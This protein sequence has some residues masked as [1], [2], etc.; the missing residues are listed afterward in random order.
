M[1]CFRIPP[2]LSEHADVFQFG[3]FYLMPREIIGYGFGFYWL[4]SYPKD[5]LLTAAPQRHK[6][7]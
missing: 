6:A 3:D 4:R 5:Y 1:R 2:V 7:L